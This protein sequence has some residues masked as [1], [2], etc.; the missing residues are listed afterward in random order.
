VTIDGF[1]KKSGRCVALHHY[2]IAAYSK[3][4]LMNGADF[5]SV[6]AHLF[7]TSKT[8]YEVVMIDI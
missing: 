2:F 8:Y 3:V 4:L 1:V 7:M 5:K 6:P